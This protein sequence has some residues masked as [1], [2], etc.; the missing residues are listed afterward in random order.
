[1]LWALLKFVYGFHF[2]KSRT[3]VMD[4][5]RE[6]LQVFLRHFERYLLIICRR[7]VALKKYSTR[8]NRNTLFALNAHFCYGLRFVHFLICSVTAQ[9]TE[10]NVLC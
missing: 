3:A 6:N 2:L 10:L 1:M 8:D 7:E 4:T 9:D 5:S